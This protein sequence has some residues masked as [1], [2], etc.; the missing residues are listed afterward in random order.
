MLRSRDVMTRLSCLLLALFAACFVA[1]CGGEE[2]TGSAQ[3]VLREAFGP[4][5]PIKTG[6]LDVGLKLN[7]SGGEGSGLSGPIDL[8]LR[9]PFRSEGTNK[10]PKFDF[11][12]TLGGGGTTFTAGA[13][14]VEDKGFVK[15]QGQSYEL[16]KATYDRFV[17][18][19]EDAAKESGQDQEGQPTLKSLGIDPLR[20]LS[21][22]QKLDEEEVGG[23]TTDHVKATVDV[24]KLLQDVDALLKKAGSLGVQDERVPQGL[25]AAERKQVQDAIKSSSFDVWAGKE[26]G[27]LR[28]LL[29]NVSFDA[30]GNGSSQAA[31]LDKGTVALDIRINEL[32]ED[33]EIKA[34]SSVRPLA[35]LTQQLGALGGGATGAGS[36]GGGGAAGS[37]GSA[38]APTE[39][40]P[41]PTSKYLQCLQDAGADLGKVQEC[42]SLVGQ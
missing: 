32:N 39:T 9:G 18:G 15:F 12:L 33:Q 31:G 27:T 10:L 17:K 16:D 5:K 3:D 2:D 6:R 25:S 21:N 42:Q 1:A 23:V 29:V 26:D 20:W 30:A 14:S 7:L 40:T 37:G 8:R 28:R 38:P 35:E 13:V 11:D 36:G 24:A 22:P 4:D 19:Y 41:R 34:P